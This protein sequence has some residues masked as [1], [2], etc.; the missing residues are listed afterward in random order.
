MRCIGSLPGVK[1][2]LF[3]SY[4][5]KEFTVSYETK[6]VDQ[7]NKKLLSEGYQGG[8]SL[9]TSFPEFGDSSLWCVTEL[10]TKKDIDRVVLGIREVLEE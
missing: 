3:N 7:V 5:F 4:H 10:H 2:P 9:K 6:T 1:S 8:F